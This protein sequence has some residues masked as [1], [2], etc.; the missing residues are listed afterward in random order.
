MN[1]GTT[2]FKDVSIDQDDHSLV[3]PPMS[4]TSL[5]TLCNE[6]PD[7]SM[8]M[9]D[10]DVAM[11]AASPRTTLCA[12]SLTMLHDSHL[13]TP[14]PTATTSRA[15][16][17]S[18]AGPCPAS[19]T[20]P[21]VTAPLNTTTTSSSSSSTTTQSHPT[22]KPTIEQ[23]PMSQLA[24]IAVHVMT[25]LM[26]NR[27]RQSLIPLILNS[28]QQQQQQN[29]NAPPSLTDLQAHHLLNTTHL[30]LSR[31]RQFA[32]TCLRISHPSTPHLTLYALLIVHKILSATSGNGNNNKKLP[33]TLASPT[34]LL[35]AGLI[36]SETMLTDSQTSASVWAKVAGISDGA[37][38]VVQLKR[39]ALDVLAWDVVVKP[40]EYEAWVLAVRKL[41]VHIG[42]ENGNGN[43]A[44]VDVKEDTM[45][46][47]TLSPSS[48]YSSFTS[49]SSPCSSTTSVD[50]D[51]GDVQG[52][53][54]RGRSS[55][56]YDDD[57]NGM[58]KRF[59]YQESATVCVME[60][61]ERSW[62]HVILS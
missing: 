32:S 13:T 40:E 47:A 18:P 30:H 5:S 51:D 53:R 27:W 16:T 19:P 62:R 39:D 59:K 20:L 35:L 29:T 1:T 31:L 9:E 48:S 56:G 8:M 60:E 17:E 12:E 45:S 42:T 44:G 34:R 21:I 58:E 3:T 2:S 54:K 10:E 7:M 23:P 22:V 43:S 38:G 41:F 46:T 14:P 25:R 55:L 61:S 37:K 36:L 6:L 33:I 52:L 28:R 4:A 50:S 26:A 24:I 11:A 49:T 57:F 15:M